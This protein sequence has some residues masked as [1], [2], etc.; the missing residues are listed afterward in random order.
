MRPDVDSVARS[1][2]R[3][4]H[5]IEEN[6]RTHPLAFLG[7]Q[8]PA[9]LEFTQVLGLGLD[10]ELDGTGVSVADR[11]DT[12]LNT[13][14]Y[15]LPTSIDLRN[16]IIPDQVTHAPLAIHAARQHEVVATVGVGVLAVLIQPLEG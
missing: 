3:R 12:G 9:H 13:H 4:T 11:L 6:E 5:V 8:H 10:H 14:S 7:R 1:E 15:T 16:G 2:V